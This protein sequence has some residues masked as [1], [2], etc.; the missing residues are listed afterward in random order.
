M[1]YQVKPFDRD[2][3]WK[4]SKKC[5]G[6]FNSLGTS[7]M[8]GAYLLFGF[9]ISRCRCLSIK[10]NVYVFTV[11]EGLGVA[12]IVTASCDILLVNGP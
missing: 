11:D 6:G 9:V 5:F 3:F 2:L 4:V 12:A 8:T 10:I 7:R 1:K